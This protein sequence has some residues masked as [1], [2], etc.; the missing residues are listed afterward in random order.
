MKFVA[1]EESK[2]KLTFVLEGETHTFCNLLVEE[3]RRT[4]GVELATY[5]IDHPLV[6][7]PHFLVQTKG[8]APR[9]AIKTALGSLK[10]TV[11][12]FAKGVK[13]L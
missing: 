3:L 4:K 11:A 5:T 9:D 6:G 2:T 13:K 1:L 7:K 12:D 8:A 10:K